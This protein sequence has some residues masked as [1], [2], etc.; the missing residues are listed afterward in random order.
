[1]RSARELPERRRPMR[2]RIT[3]CEVGATQAR[4]LPSKD[5]RSYAHALA[6]AAHNQMRLIVA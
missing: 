2:V 1:M 4:G 5:Q 3:A 6:P